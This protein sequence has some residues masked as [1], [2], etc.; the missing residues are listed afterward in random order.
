MGRIEKRAKDIVAFEVNWIEACGF[1]FQ[2][3]AVQAMEKRF[4]EAL[5]E[6]RKKTLK[7]AAKLCS[8]CSGTGRDTRST[9]YTSD[10]VQ[11]APIR[12]LAAKPEAKEG[13]RV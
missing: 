9:L 1:R 10:C 4:A 5:L 2:P 11:C 12:T 13:E 8:N 3:A 7:E 6:E